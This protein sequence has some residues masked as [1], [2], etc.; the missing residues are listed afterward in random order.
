MTFVLMSIAVTL[1]TAPECEERKQLLL[2]S[3][4]TEPVETHDSKQLLLCQDKALEYE[5]RMLL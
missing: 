3:A 2:C 5:A 1:P 4:S